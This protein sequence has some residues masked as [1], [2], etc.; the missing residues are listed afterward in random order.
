MLPTVVTTSTTII[1]YMVP[2]HIFTIQMCRSGH[3]GGRRPPA[4]AA[5]AAPLLPPTLAVCDTP[6]M[7]VSQTVAL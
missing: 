3:G 5:A 7:G 2:V 6:M 1:Y 4:A